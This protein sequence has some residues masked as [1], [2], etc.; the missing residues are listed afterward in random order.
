MFSVITSDWICTRCGI[1][2]MA[3]AAESPCCSFIL[4]GLLSPSTSLGASPV[5]KQVL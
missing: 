5:Q 1:E 4:P 3:S 2:I